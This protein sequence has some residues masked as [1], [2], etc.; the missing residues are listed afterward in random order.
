[1]LLVSNKGK[2]YRHPMESPSYWLGSV[3]P[4]APPTEANP[5]LKTLMY[6]AAVTGG[7]SGVISLIVY[8]IARAVGVPFEVLTPN[9]DAPHSIFWP[10]VVLA[11]L[12]AA[13]I[14]ALIG[15]VFLGRKH[16]RR[17]VFW[18][19]TVIALVSCVSPIVQPADVVWSTRIL[20]LFMHVITWF[21]V[22]PQ[23]ARIVGDSEPGMSMVRS[24]ADVG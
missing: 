21:L 23:L 18:G 6:A 4:V 19:G 1:M 10:L 24:T 16:A 15:A 20:L 9:A 8:A 5:T 12:V 13:V 22:V 7:W 11:P 14:G 3:T 17:I 2:R